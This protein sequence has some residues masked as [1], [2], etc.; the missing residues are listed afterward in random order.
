MS[1][2]IK[3]VQLNGKLGDIYIE[4]NLISEMGKV[5]IEA[6]HVIDGKNKA[7]IPGMVNTHTHAA[8]TLLRS[9]ADDFTLQKWLTNVIWPVEANLTEND[10]YWGTKLACLEMIKTG[11]TTFND[12]YFHGETAAKAVEEMGIRGVLSEVFFDMFDETKGEE[13]KR[14]V[15]KGIEK[16]KEFESGRIIPALGPHAIYTVSGDGLQWVKEFANEN[17]ILIHFHLAETKKEND[18]FEERYGKRPVSYLEEIGFLGE[19]LV[20]VHCVWL[21]KQDIEILAKHKVKISHNPISNMKLAV[22]K[23][24]PYNDL[25]SAGCMI[26]L[27]TDGCASNNNLDMFESMKFA[28]LGQK[29][30]TNDPTVM[31]ALEAYD[32][33]TKNGANSLR[34]NAGELK[35]G[36]L[37]DIL[38]LNLSN[39]SFNPNHNLI[40]NIVYA[41]NGSC[42]DTTICDGKVIMEGGM[43]M[44][45]E[46]IMNRASEVAG[47]LIKRS[48]EG[49]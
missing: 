32:M 15:K 22:G 34:L 9:Y 49:G 5:R 18:E 1:I 8:M 45:E 17:D 7:A 2:L 46:E 37:A 20:A 12:M 43:M 29:L 39:P 27:G 30:Y 48:L 14:K 25:K 19:N 6:E 33:A 23:V 24:L 11:T 47:E 40:A 21:N 16:L 42:V 36:K 41:A 28:A 35:E 44:G 4:E 10:I 26:S 13:G 31:P 3:E 38:L